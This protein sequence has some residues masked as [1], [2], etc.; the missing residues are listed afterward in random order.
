M[1]PEEIINISSYLSDNCPRYQ[2]TN[3]PTV[4][5]VI[6]GNS[7]TFYILTYNP[8]T[9]RMDTIMYD[10]DDEDTK[11]TELF[12]YDFYDCNASLLKNDECIGIKISE[13]YSVL[14]KAL[15]YGDWNNTRNIEN[16]SQLHMALKLSVSYDQRAE[17]PIC[18]AHIRN[19]FNDIEYFIYSYHHDTKTF[20]CI[21]YC[22]SRTTFKR[23]TYNL[24]YFM[25]RNEFVEIITRN[26][27]YIGLTFYEIRRKIKDE[28]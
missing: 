16:I 13:L 9:K 26:S 6:E 1:K 28:L 27:K 5:G 8:Y 17:E 12:L 19:I 14:G 25:K 24:K 22:K 15:T 11:K 21:E 10:N 7:Q 3:N 2:N 23:K 4:M 20:K 18:Q